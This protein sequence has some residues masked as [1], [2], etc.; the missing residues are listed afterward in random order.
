[1]NLASFS[2]S[3]LELQSIVQ[4]IKTCQSLWCREAVRPVIELPPYLMLNNLTQN[5]IK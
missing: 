3:S 5:H 1:M 4:F 2:I